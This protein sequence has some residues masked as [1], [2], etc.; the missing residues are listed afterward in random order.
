M[1]GW[2]VCSQFF[3]KA[4][5][6]SIDFDWHAKAKLDQQQDEQRPAA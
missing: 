4:E 3:H 5:E 2:L 6:G 1:R